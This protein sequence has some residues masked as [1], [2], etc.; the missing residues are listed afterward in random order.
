MVQKGSF[1]G[2]CEAAVQ[3]FLYHKKRVA[4]YCAVLNHTTVTGSQKIGFLFIMRKPWQF[5]C[6]IQFAGLPGTV[7][8]ALYMN[9]RCFDLSISDIFYSAEYFTFHGKGT[10]HATITFNPQTGTTKNPN[11]KTISS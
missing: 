2:C 4:H 5:Q 10:Q 3:L 7:G 6:V 9:A 11:F 1:C 8:G